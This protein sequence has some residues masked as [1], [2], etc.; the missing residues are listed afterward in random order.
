MRQTK[1]LR[2]LLSSHRDPEVAKTRL[3]IACIFIARRPRKLP[4]RPARLLASERARRARE[5]ERGEAAIGHHHPGIFFF[6]RV[7]GV[8]V[9]VAG[10]NPWALDGQDEQFN[11]TS[12]L[13]WL[14]ALC[15]RALALASLSFFSFASWPSSLPACCPLW[16]GTPQQNLSFFLGRTRQAS[17]PEAPAPL[18]LLSSR[19]PCSKSRNSQIT[20]PSA[21]RQGRPSLFASGPSPLPT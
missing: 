13:D 14:A 19:Q 4:L 9:I 16:C 21:P 20:Y 2:G 15:P 8:L 5:S 7:I 10:C 11:H 3:L 1:Q 12:C 18:Q 17:L 6:F